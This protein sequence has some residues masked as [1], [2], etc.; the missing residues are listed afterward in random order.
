MF[1]HFVQKNEPAFGRDVHG[2][3]SD[4][5]VDRQHPVL[6]CQTTQH[7]LDGDPGAC[8]VRLHITHTLRQFHGCVHTS[9]VGD[10]WHGEGTHMEARTVLSF[11]ASVKLDAIHIRVALAMKDA[12]LQSHYKPPLTKLGMPDV[13]VQVAP[14]ARTKRTLCKL[15]CHLS[16]A[17][18]ICVYTRVS[19]AT[20]CTA[21]NWSTMGW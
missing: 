18:S 14:R 1:L 4:T 2:R 17:P 12:T 3:N 7:A 13:I 10:I 21:L 5:L 15:C 19:L 20:L 8:H 16:S 9:R 11:T 6:R